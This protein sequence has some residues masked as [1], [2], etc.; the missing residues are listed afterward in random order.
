M[1]AEKLIPKD[2]G[3]GIQRLPMET[4]YFEAYNRPNVEL[5]DAA[6]TP[7]ERITRTGL[8]TTD[9]TFEFD[10]IVYSTGFDSFTGA[11]DQI[12][13]E[14]VGGARLRDKWADGP[15][16]YLGLLVSGFPNLIML[17]GPQSAA[18]NFPRGAEL[19]VDW[20]TPL[21]E[22]MREHGHRRF[23]A[24]ETAEAEWVEHVKEM[25]QGLLL[26]K[27]KSWITGYNSN[28]DGHEYGKTRY[29]IYNGGGPKY[30]QRLREVATSNYEGITF[31]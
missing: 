21:I 20:A 13:I 11:F 28:L 15:V 24:E 1:V 18:T 12:A 31:D 19:A 9:R 29:N 14:G 6:E 3:F 22:Y 23:D 30:A 25:Y 7:I 16:T 4:G 17:A 10:V 26:R 2:H 5:V 8:E 27:A